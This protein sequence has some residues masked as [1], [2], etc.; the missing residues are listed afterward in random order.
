M[1]KPAP[2]KSE[3]LSLKPSGPIPCENVSKDVET[4]LEVRNAIA[5]FIRSTGQHVEPDDIV[6]PTITDLNGNNRFGLI[7]PEKGDGNDW[8]VFHEGCKKKGD[9]AVRVVIDEGAHPDIS[10]Q[11]LGGGTK[12]KYTFILSLKAHDTA[13]PTATPLTSKPSRVAPGPVPVRRRGTRRNG[14]GGAKRRRSIKNKK[15]E[16]E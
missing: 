16:T 13:K 8:N 14:S 12:Y 10:T 3:I 1:R 7:L 4:A 11:Q 2:Q 9:T 6:L 15:Q 5:T